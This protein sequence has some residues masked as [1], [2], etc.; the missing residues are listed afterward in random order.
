MRNAL[1]A[2]VMGASLIGTAS[3][4]AEDRR[5]YDPYHKDYHAWN[6]GE[7]RAY[8]HWIVEERH[9]RYR[10]INRL[11]NDDRRAYWEWRH[12]HPDWR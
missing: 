3:L 9:E 11:R 4:R 1:L 6:T 12:A 10:A 8:R 7:D 5:V 2:F